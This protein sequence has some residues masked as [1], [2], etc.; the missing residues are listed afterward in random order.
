VCVCYVVVAHKMVERPD[1]AV[2][3]C[4]VAVDHKMVERPTDAGSY[5]HTHKMV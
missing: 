4:Y 5:I 3:V 1:D 2:C